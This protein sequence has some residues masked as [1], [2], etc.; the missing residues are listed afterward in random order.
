MRKPKKLPEGALERL[1]M[2]LKQAKTKAEFHSVQCLWLRASL[3]LSADQVAIVI[4]W[5]KVVPRLR[6]PKSDAATQAEFK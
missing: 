2:D 4:G 5:R 1:A 3:N 6:H